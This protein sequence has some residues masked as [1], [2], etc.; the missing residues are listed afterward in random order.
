M[1]NEYESQKDS[2]KDRNFYLSADKINDLYIHCLTGPNSYNPI[3]ACQDNS[4]KILSSG[5]EIMKY[6]TKSSLNCLCPYSKELKAPISKQ[7]MDKT[8][9]LGSADGSFSNVSLN[10]ENPVLIWSLKA[11]KD[12]ILSNAGISLIHTFDFTKNGLNEIMLARDD[13]TLELYSLN[14]NGEMELM[15]SLVSNDAITGIDCGVFSQNNNN[16]YLISTYSG[17]IFGLIDNEDSK[18]MISD[19]KKGKE[20]SKNM[21]MKIKL[22]REEVD[23]LKKNV[24]E[25]GSIDNSET[26][27]VK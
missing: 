20:N 23:K 27:L 25:L 3:L 26:G 13:G 9:I 16:E 5:K 2:I 12:V 6:D 14:V 19:S 8:M 7:Q 24:D 18:K 22:L 21:E 17:K 15:Y 4:L 1:L 11:S 10:T